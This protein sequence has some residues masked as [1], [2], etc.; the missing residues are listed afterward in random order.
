M[1]IRLAR[2]DDYSAIADLYV[3]NHNETY[4]GL[5]PDRYFTMLT[6]DYAQKKWREY[7]AVSG[8]KLWI[9]CE[10][11]RFLGFSAGTADKDL[12][13]TWLVDSLHVAKETRGK[14][15]GTALIHING[16]F[17]VYNG[18]SKMSICVVRGN[19]NARL[20]YEKLG[21][22]HHSF[23]DDTFCHSISHSEKLI[24]NHLDSF[25]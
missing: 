21:A 23:F 16:A 17:A 24:W 2:P 10:N 12:P 6:P 13:D 9:A 25:K 1:M 14:G 15:V 3:S 11:G 22:R 5:L 8:R 20:L 4:K 19:E 18:F 7:Q